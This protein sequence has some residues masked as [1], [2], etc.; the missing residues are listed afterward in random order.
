VGPDID[1]MMVHLRL[2]RA[3]L[4]QLL[5]FQTPPR[6]LPRFPL[7]TLRASQVAY[8]LLGGLRLKMNQY[9]TRNPRIQLNFHTCISDCVPWRLGEPALMAGLNVH[10][11]ALQ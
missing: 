7:A 4:L 9:Q 10:S 1:I 11:P 8:A 6:R 3:L 5:L 2:K